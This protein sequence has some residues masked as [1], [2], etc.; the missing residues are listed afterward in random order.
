M[1]TW[2]HLDTW[3]YLIGATCI[4]HHSCQHSPIRGR[5]PHLV[6]ISLIATVFLEGDL[7]I[8]HSQISPTNL[9]RYT[10]YS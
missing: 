6:P 8:P 9:P 5:L 10:K 3:I 2:F 7:Y 1:K 4:L